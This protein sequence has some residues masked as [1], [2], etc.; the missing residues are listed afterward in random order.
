MPLNKSN[1]KMYSGSSSSNF[2]ANNIGVSQLQAQKIDSGIFAE[3]ISI[4]AMS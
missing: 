3:N 4:N 2:I 1:I